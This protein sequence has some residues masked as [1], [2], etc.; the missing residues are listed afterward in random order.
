MSQSDYR[1]AAASEGNPKTLG[2]E[3][4]RDSGIKPIC[5]KPQGCEENKRSNDGKLKRPAPQDRHVAK[6]EKK[7]LMGRKDD[8]PKG[9]E[10]GV[11][12]LTTTTEANG[13]GY[14]GDSLCERWGKEHTWTKG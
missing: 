11:E 13:G 1:S 9:L 10:K 2:G 5:R 3:G 7:D 14:V 4:V 12:A 8:G 6:I